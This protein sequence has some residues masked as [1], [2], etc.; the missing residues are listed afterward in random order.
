MGT[1]PSISDPSAHRQTKLYTGNGSSYSY[2]ITNDG[3]SDLKP[4]WLWIKGRSVADNHVLYDSVR[5]NTKQLKANG[6]DQEDTTSHVNSFN[7]D[8][9]TLTSSDA[10]FNQ[11]SGS[12]LAWQWKLAGGSNT[13][14]YDGSITSSVQANTTAGLSI[15]TYTGNGTNDATV[16][17]GLGLAPKMIWVK[18]R[19]SGTRDWVIFHT[20]MGTSKELFLNSTSAQAN[21][22][23]WRSQPGTSTFA[24]SSDNYVNGNGEKYIAYV[25]AEVLGYSAANYYT[26]TGN[27]SGAFNH[28]G[29]RPGWIIVKNW[30][31]TSDWQ[32]LD[33]KRR[34]LTTNAASTEEAFNRNLYRLKPN[35]SQAED[36]Q[37]DVDILANGFKIRTSSSDWN[38]NNDN[39]MWYASADQ[40]VVT[41][42]G[43]PGVGL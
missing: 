11:N 31:S 17:H 1:Y 20:W 3:N 6:N 40:P 37:I 12:Y 19:D 24:L 43:V 5:G 14:N 21:S 2:A 42:A 32:V 28:T 22:N 39:Y 30:S 38:A 36:T 23:Y 13:T 8:G 18:R 35:S 7:T 33:T 25:F 34:F 27:T 41:S 29:F 10:A 9:F 15:V 4:D 16:G 26:G